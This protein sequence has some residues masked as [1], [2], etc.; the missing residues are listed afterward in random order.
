MP[1]VL[2][3]GRPQRH[4]PSALE[5]KLRPC[6]LSPTCT[7][8]EW[9]SRRRVNPATLH[10]GEETAGCSGMFTMNDQA[11]ASRRAR[12][13]SG[14]ADQR[15]FSMPLRSRRTPPGPRHR[16][17]TAMVRNPI[18]AHPDVKRMLMRCRAADRGRG[19]RTDL[20]RHR[21][22]ATS[23]FGAGR[24]TQTRPAL[25]RCA[26]GNC[27]KR[28][29]WGGWVGGGGGG[30]GGGGIFSDPQK[31]FSDLTIADVGDFRLACRSMAAWG[32]IE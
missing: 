11:S 32:F 19:A 13:R 5:H 31:L 21:P 7:N 10:T 3:W 12:G 4:Y 16:Q 8:Y 27:L 20:L 25:R 26:R 22:V 9:R 17:G 1:Y 18:I 28:R 15:L 23:S 29:G 24:P 2:G 6:M 14:I 30:G